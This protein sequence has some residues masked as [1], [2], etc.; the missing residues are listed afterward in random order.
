MAADDLRAQYPGIF[1]AV[2]ANVIQVEPELVR[3]IIH[4]LGDYIRLKQLPGQPGIPEGVVA[5]QG[6][7]AEAHASA[8]NSRQREQECP[9]AP[10]SLVSGYESCVGTAEAAAALGISADTVRWHYRKANLDG[11]R[12]GRQLMVTTASIEN[13]KRR[14]AERSA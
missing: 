6:A 13:L 5:A 10:V 12:V 8:S 1:S 11:R 4:W 14:K 2:R 7:L 3:F 9:T